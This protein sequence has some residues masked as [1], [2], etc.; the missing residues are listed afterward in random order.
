MSTYRVNVKA[1]IT[2]TYVVDAETAE[3][4]EI[5]VADRFTFLEEEGIEEYVTQ[6]ISSTKLVL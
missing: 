1:T 2:K 5:L 4:A 3:E 6:E